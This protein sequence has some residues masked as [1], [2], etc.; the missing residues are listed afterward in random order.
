MAKENKKTATLTK[1]WGCK[2]EKGFLKIDYWAKVFT[3]D[4]VH[5]ME[6]LNL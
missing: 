6:K 3:N 5:S 1:E 2:N 4:E